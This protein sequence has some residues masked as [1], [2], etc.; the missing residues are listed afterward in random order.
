MAKALVLTLSARI[1]LAALSV[2]ALASCRSVTSNAPAHLTAPTVVL[3]SLDGFRWDYP[4][5]TTTPALDRLAREGMSAEA[6]RPVFP[7]LTFPNHFSIATGVLPWRHGIVANR[8]PDAERQR[9]YSMGDRSAVEDGTWYLA[10]PIWVT[11]EKAGMRTA[12]YYFVGTEADIGGVHPSRWRSFDAS[13]P[14]RARVSQVLD[15]LDEPGTTRPRLLTLYFETVDNAGHASGPGSPVT[16]DAIR[17]VDRQ[18]GSLLDGID[19]LPHSDEVYVVV[20]SDHGQAGYREHPPF[21]LEHWV[22]LDDAKVVSGGPY[23]WIYLERDR[24]RAE[25]MRESINRN[26]DCGRA[27]LPGELPVEWST[28]TSDRY[29]DVFVQADGGCEVL[30]RESDWKKRTAGDHGWS[31]DLPEMHGIFYAKGPRIEPGTTTAVTNVTDVYPLLMDILGLEAPGP[32]DGD[33]A[34]LAAYLQPAG[35]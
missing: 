18:L 12:A 29:P 9:W 20:V 24:G 2:V 8:F 17:Q 6:L 13:V 26:W 10:E 32:I 7:T 27:Y 31:P 5:A 35:K 19:A 33:P 16:L 15:W 4:R 3:V 30:A 14:D 1:F 21:V 22:D 25:V 34:A 11:A 28:G 23:A